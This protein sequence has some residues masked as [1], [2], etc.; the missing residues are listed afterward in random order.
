MY[1]ASSIL[2]V[3]HIMNHPIH[4]NMGNIDTYFKSVVVFQNI[5]SCITVQLIFRK[6]TGIRGRLPL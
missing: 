1:I 2:P 3:K 6:K 5:R 4:I